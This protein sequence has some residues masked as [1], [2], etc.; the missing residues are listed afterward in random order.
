MTNTSKRHGIRDLFDVIKYKKQRNT[1]LNMYHS[2][3]DEYILALE[4]TQTLVIQNLELQKQLEKL[5]SERK[6]LKKII[7]EGTS[8]KVNKKVRV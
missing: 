2:R 7:E 6:E 1:A 4:T 5:K 3:N 8:K